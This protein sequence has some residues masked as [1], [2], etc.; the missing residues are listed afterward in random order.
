MKNLFL[1][2]HA[3]AEPSGARPSDHDRTLSPTGRL[4]AERMGNRLAAVSPDYLITS[5]AVRARETAEIIAAAV[6]FPSGRI[7][8][9][10][11]LYLAEPRMIL[12][13]V[14]ALGD[15]DTVMLFA[16]NP[17]LSELAGRLHVLRAGLPTCGVA[18]FE[19]QVD[20]WADFGPATA[21]FV[22]LYTPAD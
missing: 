2:R 17:G 9:D 12:D 8:V 11:R 15:V 20:S 7:V 5:T 14:R 6:H 13:A 16:H 21:R 22:G 18:A 4:E 10:G 19:A 3:E 1:I